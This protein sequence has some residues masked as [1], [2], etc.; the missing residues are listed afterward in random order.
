LIIFEL[1]SDKLIWARTKVTT[2]IIIPF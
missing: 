1:P 2:I